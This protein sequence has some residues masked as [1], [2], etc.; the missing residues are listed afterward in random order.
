MVTAEGLETATVICSRKPRPL[1]LLDMAV[2]GERRGKQEAERRRES[3]REINQVL[4]E[5]DRHVW[6]I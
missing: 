5:G 1:I 3:A 6:E 2:E 4:P